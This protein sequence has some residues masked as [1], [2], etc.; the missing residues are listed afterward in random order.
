MPSCEICGAEKVSTRTITVHGALVQGCKQCQTKIGHI[1]DSES[2]A[3]NI[4]RAA[5]KASNVT[6]GGYG[7]LG[8]AGKDIMVRDSKEL[9]SDFSSIIRDAR[10]SRGWDQRTLAHRMK[11]K[12]NVIQRTEAGQRPADELIKKFERTLDVT[13]LIEASEQSFEQN[14]GTKNAR[15]MSLGDYIKIAREEGD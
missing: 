6:S 14:I 13:L 2:P 15:S 12:I 11:E 5:N 7:G 10:N 8:T 3:Q 4:Q 9:V 1:P